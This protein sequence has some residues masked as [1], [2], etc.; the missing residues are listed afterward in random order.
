M[1]AITLSAACGETVIDVS[2]LVGDPLNPETHKAEIAA[3]DAI[4]FEDGALG[5]PERAELVHRLTALSKVAQA[6]PSNTIAVNSGQNMKRF[7]AG[8][9]RT[10]VGTTRLELDDATTVAALPRRS[11]Q[12]RLLVPME[13][14]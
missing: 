12:R 9:E 4:V 7:A 13:F 1:L 2:K 8:V 6:D 3:I 11:L 14:R 5:A 10:P